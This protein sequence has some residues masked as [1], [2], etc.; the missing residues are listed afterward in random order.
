MADPEGNVF[1]YNRRWYEYT[2]TTLEQMA[3]WHWQSVH[4]PKQL[5]AVMERWVHSIRTGNSFD[6]EFPLKG[7]DG[8]FRSFLTRVAPFR[9]AAGDIVLWFG[10]NTDIEDRRRVAEERAQSLERE[11]A[12]RAEAEA[13]NQA[14]DRFLA[15]LSHELRTPLTPV[16]ATVTF[17]EKRGDLPEE[18]RLEIGTIRRNIELEARLVDDLLDLTRISRGKIE[19]HR[20]I[21][22][23]HGLIRAAAEVVR[24]ESDAKR[25]AVTLQLRAVRHHCW[26][27]PTRIQQVLINL[28]Q[29]AVR[30]TPE[31]G[32]AVIVSTADDGTALR[33]EVSDSGVGID[34]AILPKLFTAFEQGERTVTRG[35][36]GL[37]LG[38]AISKSFVEM[39]DG[40]LHGFSQGRGK[41]A[42]FTVTLAT[43]PEAIVR[44]QRAAPGPAHRKGQRCTILLVEDHD[45]TRRVMARLL[46]SFGCDVKTAG[47]VAEARVIAEREPIDL[48]LS[49]IGLPD[50]TGHDVMA[51][52]RSK[53]I[54]GVAISG[55]GRD[56][57]I[58]RSRESGFETH[59][60]KPV[61]F[62]TLENVVRGVTAVR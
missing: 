32:G 46:K 51:H 45:D 49:D 24:P 44:P 18:L 56:E 58:R 9:N 35:L 62:Q 3:G 13:A 2:G 54:R 10:T 16:L 41:G 57:D 42:T 1:W 20:E 61:N 50:G 55:F 43:M 19:L 21:A 17:V 8:T 25:V 28:M 27:D 30:Y 36:G 12:A 53:G 26:A 59:L 29:N 38:L 34:P 52:A 15:V 22:D 33:M 39:H 5:A 23:V 37:G 6:M 11:R 31:G 48:L 7:A 4:D 47:T 60:V 40:A 14:K